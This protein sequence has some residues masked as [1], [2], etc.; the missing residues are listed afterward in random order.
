MARKLEN[1]AR[2]LVGKN[3]K[4]GSG[5]HKKL[6][7]NIRSIARYMERYSLG[8]IKH[9]KTKHVLNYFEYQKQR[10]LS[11]STLQN[12]ATA[13]RFLA[14]AIGKQ[15]IVPRTNHELGIVRTGR[16][17]PKTSD[18]VQQEL[19]R[20]ALYMKHLSLGVAHDLRAAFGLRAQ[21]SITARVV[22]RSG[23]ELIRVTGKGGRIREIPVDTPE[24]S[25]ALLAF[26]Q[27]VSD[28]GTTGLIPADKT[29]KQFYTFQKN[30]V[31]RAGSTK[32]SM[33]NMHTLRHQR[34]QIMERDGKTDKE[35]AVEFGHDREDS[36]RFYK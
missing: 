19:L 3:W 4:K 10:G 20:E 6:L 15:N 28:Q 8:S 26:K 13:M 2:Q 32:T 5:T 29:L 16:Y 30:A 11:Q 25:M 24:K 31:Y 12:H 36:A 17:S 27:F 34:A 9:M 1:E 18:P 35:I 21:E 14:Q 23:E 7:S 22:V 33:S